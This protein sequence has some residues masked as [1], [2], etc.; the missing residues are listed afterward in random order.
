MIT[1]GET[2]KWRR[3]SLPLVCAS[4]RRH[5]AALGKLALFLVCYRER[6]YIDSFDI[7]Y[8]MIARGDSVDGCGH[9]DDERLALRISVL[10]EL[11]LDGSSETGFAGSV[12]PRR[13]ATIRF[14]L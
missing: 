4:I 1:I 12:W 13:E 14:E 7:T 5:G 8:A 9:D 6:A 3:A 10:E 11:Y 2:A